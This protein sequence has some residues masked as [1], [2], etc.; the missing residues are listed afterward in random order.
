MIKTNRLKARFVEKG[1][2][3]QDIARELGITDVTLSRK[4]NRG[5][6][7]SDE[8]YKMIVLLDIKDPT[9]IFFAE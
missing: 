9:E 8:I 1:Y 2:T 6:F 3:Q 7:N 5:V 4:L